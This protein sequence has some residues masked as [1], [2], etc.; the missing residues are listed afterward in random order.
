SGVIVLGSRAEGKACFVA[1]VSDDLV[2]RG[3]HAGK[4]MARLAKL[5]GGGGGGQPQKAQAGGK[6]ASKVADAIQRTPE[7]LREMTQAR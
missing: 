6:D 7:F 4:L 3:L 5:A 1:S 2:A